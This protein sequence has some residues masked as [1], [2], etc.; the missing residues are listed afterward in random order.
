[1]SSSETI[2]GYQNRLFSLADGTLMITD[3]ENGLLHISRI[4][5]R[6]I[7][8]VGDVLRLGQH[9]EVSVIEIDSMRRRISLSMI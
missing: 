5:T 1:M 3:L 2:S 9:I 7:N 6:R 8:S 4:S